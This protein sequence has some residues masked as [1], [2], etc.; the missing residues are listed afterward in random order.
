MNERASAYKVLLKIE[1]NGSY[2]NLALD[3]ELKE[4][5]SSADTA[6]IT[7]LVYGTLERQVTIDY[8]LSKYLNKPVKKTKPEILTV[9]R[10]GVYQILFTDKIPAFAAVNES[11]KIIK[12]SGFS[13]A[14]GLVNSV[15]RK[16]SSEEFKYPET[17]DEY[18]DLSIRYSCPL[19]LV[20]HFYDGYGKKNAV[21]ILS[22]SLGAAPLTVTVNT[23]KT[24]PEELIRILENEG[25]KSEVKDENSLVITDSVRPDVLDS[26]KNGLFHVQDYSSYLCCKT[27]SP[28]EN[29]TVIDVCAAPGGK[30]FTISEM[31]N[32]RGKVYSCDLYSSRVNLINDGAK[33]LGIDIITSLVNDASVYNDDLPLADRV[34]CDVPCSGLGVIGRKKEI[35]FKNPAE[36]DNLTD[37]QY[38]ILS[39]SSQYVR[40]GGVLVY[41]TCTLNKKENEDNC[42][43]F[44]DEHKDFRPDSDF[45]N[46]FPGMYNSDGFFTARF[47]RE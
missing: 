6:L 13:F 47:V 1:K 2:S 43:R 23:L 20:K 10:L 3:A 33:R 7:N 27:L 24:T 21:D 19:P 29:E 44:L 5:S 39:V 26:F 31:M 30:S 36:F 40:K 9:L 35:R 22:S 41:S 17:D 8:V 37:M 46:I 25:V 32:N 45:L 15:L 16:I 14:S 4:L 12:N 28:K 38:N 42:N 34:L 18:F 11:V